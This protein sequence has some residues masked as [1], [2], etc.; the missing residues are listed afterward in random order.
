MIIDRSIAERDL[1]RGIALFWTSEEAV[2]VCEFAVER[3]RANPAV[4]VQREEYEPCIH[5][6][7]FTLWVDMR[8]G[9]RRHPFCLAAPKGR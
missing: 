5:C 6:G 9:E 8:T 2:R 4:W 7:V 1:N 3:A